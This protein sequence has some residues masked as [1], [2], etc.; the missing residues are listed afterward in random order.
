MNDDKYLTYILYTRLPET[1]Q[2]PPIS[3]HQA[4]SGLLFYA[5]Q[6]YFG[7]HITDKDLSLGEHGKPYLTD[8]PNVEFNVSHSGD[9]AVL[10]L[11]GVPVGID[12]QEK[13]VMEIDKLG[14][15]IFT[16][17]DY[18]KFLASSDRQELFFREW[19]RKESYVK[20]TGE[21]L[22]HTISE[23]D[24]C[25]WSRFIYIDNHYY[26][27]ICAETPLSLRIE[28]VLWQTYQKQ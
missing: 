13:K 6:K 9:Y 12:I 8:Y 22:I 14:K 17:T 18:R 10:A 15:K 16:P 19:V 3:G 2:D 4:A 27:M 1:K 20:M 26:C 7:I 11:S 23:I 28:E 24:P 25:G 5:L 21:G